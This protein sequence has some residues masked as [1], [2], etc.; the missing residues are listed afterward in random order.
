M[1]HIHYGKHAADLPLKF[2]SRRQASGETLAEYFREFYRLAH[3][4]ILPDDAKA[5]LLECLTQVIQNRLLLQQI[6]G[7]IHHTLDVLIAIVHERVEAQQHTEVQAVGKADALMDL[8]RAFVQVR[9]SGTVL[10]D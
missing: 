5:S 2:H 10:S 4:S 3:L 8:K 9:G 7:R 6:N 1:P